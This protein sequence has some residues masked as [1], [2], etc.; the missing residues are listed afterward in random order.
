MESCIFCKIVR[1]E[2]PSFKVYEDEKVLAFEDINPISLGHTLVIP[3]NHA[4]DLWE[5]AEEDL[6]AVH[7]AS[8]KITQGIA[9]ALNPIGV[10]CLQLNGPG[11]N[12]VVLHYH[13]HLIPRVSG[14]PELPVANWELKKGDI[15]AIKATAEKIAA[16]IR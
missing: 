14:G 10:A 12:Q 15:S 1:G 4:K 13:L 8:K 2:I 11:A 7:L 5:I 16:A 9:K 6:T 3:R